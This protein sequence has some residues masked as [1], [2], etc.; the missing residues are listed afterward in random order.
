MLLL[1]PML[2][3]KKLFCMALEEHHFILVSKIN[4]AM[5]LFGS[6]MNSLG[7]EYMILFY[8]YLSGK[9]EMQK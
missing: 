1:V 5:M 4:L 6:M 8:M 9:L 2:L 7:D 3:G